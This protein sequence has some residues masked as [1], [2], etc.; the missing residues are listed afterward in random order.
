MPGGGSEGTHLS[1]QLGQIGADDDDDAADGSEGG[2]AFSEGG[3]SYY[4]GAS[5]PAY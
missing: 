3:G 5:E 1:I 4:S 2:D